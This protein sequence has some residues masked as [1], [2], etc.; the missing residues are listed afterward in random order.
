MAI[1]NTQQ[2][3]TAAAPS[4]A[5]AAS[6]SP[7]MNYTNNN[8]SQAAPQEM[9]F[10]FHGSSL[11]NSP[12]NE[13]PGSD[14]LL[15][16]DSNLSKVL[17]GAEHFDFKTFRLEAGQP[18]EFGSLRISLLVVAGVM[19]SNPKLVAYHT[20]ILDGTGEPIEPKM[21]QIGGENVEEIL[22]PSAVFDEVAVRIIQ[23]ALRNTYKN[24]ELF[25]ADSEVIHS[26]FNVN[27]GDNDEVGRIR[28]QRLAANV[29]VAIVTE[30]TT[31]QPNFVGLNLRN[32]ARDSNLVVTPRFE[33][34]TVSGVDE[35]P[36]R[37]DIRIELSS[38]QTRQGNQQINSLNNG[39]RT[40]PIS[41]SSAFVDFLYSP[42]QPQGGFAPVNPNAPKHLYSAN[43]IITEMRS[44]KI[45][46]ISGYLLALACVRAVTENNNWYHVFRS[47]G[48]KNSMNDI[49]YLNI[50]ANIENNPS[51]VGSIIDTSVDSFTPANQ[52]QYLSNIIR[53]G[54][55]ISVDVPESGPESWAV[56]AFSIASSN[57]PQ[58]RAAQMYIYNQAQQLT[59][60]VFGQYFSENEDMFTNVGNRI[61]MGYYRDRDGQLRDIREIDYVSVA[62]TSKDLDQI[63]LWSDTYSAH[64][65]PLL[66][67]LARRKRII[68]AI[69]GSGDP[70]ITGY[71]NRVTFNGKFLA[72]LCTALSSIG[73]VPRLESNPFNMQM[74]GRGAAN[75]V[76]GAIFNPA[77]GG[78]FSQGMGM[79]GGF[80]S[81]SPF[82][83]NRF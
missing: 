76:D 46:T 47:N 9:A 28:I 22:T 66:M 38:Q 17:T 16:L 39:D 21:H 79:G 69:A 61:H 34:G 27:V 82:G 65:I 11:I 15:T 59:G 83:G 78:F 72:A 44:P 6:P 30:L 45:T 42:V 56:A 20:L 49:G 37:Q 26:G 14:R 48:M 70:K 62:A 73:V 8:I 31:R 43:I 4:S 71:A 74:A 12:V 35:L 29:S 32:W 60:G 75:W 13:N 18:T 64:E 5:P 57:S 68:Q 53:P 33:R 10:S 24:A 77:A 2:T 36:R 25:S 7:K 23:Q 50:E 58:A 51:G 52:L 41:Q 55:V 67:R 1:H 54:A 80:N 3:E 40:V 63:K 81:Y 19:K